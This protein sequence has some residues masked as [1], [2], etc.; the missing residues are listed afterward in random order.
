MSLF[1]V[2]RY[3]VTNCGDLS[4]ILAVP[5]E[6]IRPW[7]DECL[8]MLNLYKDHDTS[9][10]NNNQMHLL[11]MVAVMDAS[12]DAEGRPVDQTQDVYLYYFTRMLRKRIE[13][14]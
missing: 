10:M 12:K 8:L 7:V 3:P 5:T 9:R 1:D 4:Q 14:A 11:L 6:I 13:D 2:I